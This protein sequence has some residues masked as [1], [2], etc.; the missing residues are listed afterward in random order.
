V[1]F[2][3]G[4]AYLGGTLGVYAHAMSR[5]ERDGERLLDLVNGSTPSR[6]GRWTRRALSSGA[7]ARDWG[8]RRPSETRSWDR[9]ESHPSPGDS[10]PGAAGPH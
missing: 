5:E 10:P 6:F 8:E 2:Q 4:H 3:V 9:T 1:C 7:T